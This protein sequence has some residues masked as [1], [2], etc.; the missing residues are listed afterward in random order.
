[1]RRSYA[2]ILTGA[3]ASGALLAPGCG[4]NVQMIYEGN[5]RFEHCYRLDLDSS[6]AP[7]HRRACWQD[8]L[9]RHTY[10]QTGDRLAHARQRLTELNHGAQ[11]TLPILDDAGVQQRQ[12]SAPVPMPTNIH[13]APPP[14][15]PE[16]QPVAVATTVSA[17][18]SALPPDWGCLENCR[19]QWQTCAAP[20]QCRDAAGA[21]PTGS[22]GASTVVPDPGSSKD[23]KDSCGTC[24][25]SFKNCAVR[26]GH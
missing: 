12:A 24:N 18:P 23:R 13:S 25:R 8:W 19:K 22:G 4:P 9:A 5:V 14:K 17:A 6:I 10:G 21:A 2:R 7:S 20:L 1:M 3:A 26:C 15:A 16:A 11:A